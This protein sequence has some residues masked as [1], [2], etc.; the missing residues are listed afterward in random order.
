MAVCRGVF[1]SGLNKAGEQGMGSDGFTEKLGV[2]LAG[3]VEGV[4]LQFDEF[5]QSTKTAPHLREEPDSSRSDSP[6]IDAGK[7][8]PDT[9]MGDPHRDEH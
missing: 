4:I 9:T 1:A 5:H 2:K 3:H 6:P 8:S 7:K